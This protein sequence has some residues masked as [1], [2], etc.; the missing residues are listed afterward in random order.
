[1]SH[2]YWIT[3]GACHAHYAV[4]FA[5]TYV[6]GKHE[7]INIFLVPIRDQNLKEMPGVYIED[8]GMKQGCN[9]VD[10]AKLVFN[11]VRV[12]RKMLLNKICNITP[13]G[14]FTHKVQKPRQR[15]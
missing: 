8:M 4:V 14:K 11:K 10:N 6:K 3:N 7:G 1:M 5:Q 2:K 9:G 13:D 15:F 12:D